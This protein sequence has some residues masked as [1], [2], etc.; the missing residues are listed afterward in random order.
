MK[1]NRRDY[2]CVGVV[3]RVLEQL[4]YEMRIFGIEILCEKL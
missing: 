1:L 2:I 3:V 4:E